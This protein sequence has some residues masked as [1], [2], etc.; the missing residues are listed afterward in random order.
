MGAVEAEGGAGA[1]EAGRRGR[2][3]GRTA[4]ARWRPEGNGARARGGARRG[5]HRRS[6]RRAAAR[7]TEKF[8]SLTAGDWISARWSLSKMR[9]IGEEEEAEQF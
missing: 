1:V 2:D 7:R 6:G 4:R 3:G 8:G 5:R 9:G